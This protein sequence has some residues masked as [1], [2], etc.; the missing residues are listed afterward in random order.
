MAS[1][2][3]FVTC[4]RQGQKEMLVALIK[5]YV[6]VAAHAALGPHRYIADR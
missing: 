6:D 5:L 2:R 3:W 1:G 4:P